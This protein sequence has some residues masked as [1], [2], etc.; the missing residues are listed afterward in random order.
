MSKSRCRIACLA[1]LLLCSFS[2]RATAASNDPSEKQLSSRTGL[3]LEIT[4]SSG[5]PFTVPIVTS[6]QRRAV[7]PLA[8][9][10]AGAIKVIPRLTSSGVEVR[11]YALYGDFSKANNKNWCAQDAAISSY[12]IGTYNLNLLNNHTV[13]VDSA[14]DLGSTSVQL[15]LLP[16]KINLPEGVLKLIEDPSAGGCCG[17]NGLSCCPNK[18]YCLDCSVCGSC[19]ASAT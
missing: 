5:V 13:M 16:A 2:V 8:G 15:R 14:L 6:S 4:K 7:I 17:C 1:T 11:I 10:P 19:C 12:T 3:V 18:G 9:S